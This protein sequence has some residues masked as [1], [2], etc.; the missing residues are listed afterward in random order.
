LE[1]IGKV[2]VGG[3]A[4]GKARAYGCFLT[5]WYFVTVTDSRAPYASDPL[6]LPF[7]VILLQYRCR[8]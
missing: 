7:H 1:G 4:E 3:W 6:D 2:G 5:L 8:N